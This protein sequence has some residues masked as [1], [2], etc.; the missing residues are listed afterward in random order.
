MT[1]MK[2]INSWIDRG[3]EQNATHMIVMCDTFSYEDYP[4]FVMEGQNPR[5]IAPKGNMQTPM[6]CYDLR[7]NIE[8]QMDEIRANHWEV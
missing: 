8:E 2:E 6:E 3:L 1:T 4:V 7:M 5:D